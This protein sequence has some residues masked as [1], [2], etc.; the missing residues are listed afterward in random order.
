MWNRFDKFL[1]K[2]EKI[3]QDNFG[4]HWKIKDVLFA[5]YSNQWGWEPQLAPHFDDVFKDHKLT[6][7]LRLNGNIDWN[8]V[9]EDKPFLLKNKSKR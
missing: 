9:V 1:N 3:V 7:D 4:Q 8:I 2:I 6:F 5:K